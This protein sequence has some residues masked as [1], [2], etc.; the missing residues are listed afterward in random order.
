MPPALA[1]RGINEPYQSTF[2][3]ADSPTV[4]EFVALESPTFKSTLDIHPVISA[5]FFVASSKPLTRVGI[6]ML[7]I[8]PSEDEEHVDLTLKPVSAFLE[9]ENRLYQ[10]QMVFQMLSN[11]TTIQ[12][13][14]K[15]RIQLRVIQ[16][17]SNYNGAPPELYFC[18]DN[19]SYLSISVQN[20]DPLVDIV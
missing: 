11:R 8:S 19:G 5:S 13:G 18:N 20:Y 6:R 1:E 7:D 10:I 14:H 4:T 17:F 3:T 15:I 16:T 12:T 9:E 2:F